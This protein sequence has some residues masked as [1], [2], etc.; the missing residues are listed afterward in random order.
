MIT[1]RRYTEQIVKPD[2]QSGRK[3]R[4]RDTKYR[5]SIEKGYKDQCMAVYRPD[6]WKPIQVADAGWLST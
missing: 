3:T 2:T 5:H 1:E 6:R 4:H